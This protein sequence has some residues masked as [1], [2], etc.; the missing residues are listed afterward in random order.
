[1]RVVRQNLAIWGIINILGLILVFKNL[2]GPEGAA[3]YNFLTD[4]LPLLN[5]LKLFKLHRES[6]FKK[7]TGKIIDP[8]I[9]N[10]SYNSRS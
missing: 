4:F 8:P 6:S 7:H 9:E 5:S 3:A 2:V 1:M 10:L